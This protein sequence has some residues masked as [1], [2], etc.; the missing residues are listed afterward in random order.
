MTSVLFGHTTRRTFVRYG[1]AGVAAGAFGAV[2]AWRAYASG[3]GSFDPLR[4]NLDPCFD[5]S[6]VK[7]P[8]SASLP[9]PPP[10]RGDVL[11]IAE[12]RS[13]AEIIPGIA[14]P[15]WGYD[16]RVPGPTILARKGRPVTVTFTNALP[17]GD[18]A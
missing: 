10:L 3:S 1:A 8:F 16:G 2:G 7:P 15:V 18:D 17:P 11:T 12:R 13:V 14:T 4:D 9:I 6:P 5:G